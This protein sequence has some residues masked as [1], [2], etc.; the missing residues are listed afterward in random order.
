[1]AVEDGLMPAAQHTPGPWIWQHWPDGVDAVAQAS[2]LGTIATIQSGAFA[3]EDQANAR[4]IAAAPD[5]LEAC[6]KLIEWDDREKDHAI[7]FWARVGLCKEA[8]EAMR[9]AVTK[10]DGSAS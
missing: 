3:D 9:A 10:A 7:D 8:F 4:L 5:L 6:K 2:T 1:M